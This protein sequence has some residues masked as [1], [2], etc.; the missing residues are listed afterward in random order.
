MGRYE[1]IVEKLSISDFRVIAMALSEIITKGRLTFMNISDEDIEQAVS[2]TLKKE[3]EAK[4]TGH[5]Y[6]LDADFVGDLIRL[7]REISNLKFEEIIVLIKK[8]YK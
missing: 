5:I 7:E 6:L 2:D 8:I 1:K 4:Q 3:E